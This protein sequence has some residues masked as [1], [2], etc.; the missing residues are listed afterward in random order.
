MPHKKIHIVHGKLIKPKKVHKQPA[1]RMVAT[2][3]T[4][5]IETEL[6]DEKGPELQFVGQGFN[7]KTFILQRPKKNQRS[8]N[9]KTTITN[10]QI[11]NDLVTGLGL[12]NFGSSLQ[13]TKSK[14]IKLII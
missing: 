8:N 4:T 13:N 5:K 1:D 12:L 6:V 10:Q 9:N 2:K 14:N 7:A 3:S 11:N